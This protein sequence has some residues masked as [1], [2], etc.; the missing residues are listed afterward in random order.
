MDWIRSV[1]G[2]GLGFVI[3]VIGSAMP[4]SAT[5]DGA[6]PSVGLV[7]GSIVYGAVFA[8]LGGL[9]A[10][11]LAGRKQLLHGAALAALIAVAALLH[12][13]LEA[14]SESSLA[15]PLRCVSDG[16]LCGAR[17]VGARAAAPPLSPGGRYTSAPRPMSATAR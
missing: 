3:F 11:S 16:P 8:A 10:A 1:L 15:G 7:V 14:A 6:T 5:G 12:P 13:W 2:V 9:T 4:R 17:G